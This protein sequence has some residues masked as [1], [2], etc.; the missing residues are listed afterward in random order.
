M[1]LTYLLT[2]WADFTKL[3]DSGVSARVYFLRQFLVSK[4]KYLLRT[5]FPQIVSFGL[6]KQNSDKPRNLRFASTIQDEGTLRVIRGS[7]PP[8]MNST[9]PDKHEK[10]NLNKNIDGARRY[11]CR[12]T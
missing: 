4:N 7:K 9:V 12:K 3:A 1:F 2:Y 5:I 8:E 11:S 10:K 6:N